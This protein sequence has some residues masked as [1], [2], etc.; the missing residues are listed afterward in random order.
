MGCCPKIQDIAV[1]WLRV[2]LKQREE[3]SAERMKFCMVCEFNDAG[4]CLKCPTKIKCRVRA[5]TRVESQECPMG[6]WKSIE[7]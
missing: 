3:L 4:K 2:A 5:K 6:R 7:I 1:G